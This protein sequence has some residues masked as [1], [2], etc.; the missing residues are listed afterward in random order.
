MI[1]TPTR[2]WTTG[3]F[4]KEVEGAGTTDR[5]PGAASLGGRVYVFA[6]GVNDSRVYVNSAVAG[7]PFDGWGNGWAEVQW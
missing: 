2:R 1:R 3:I 5:A 7:N 4:T 6:K